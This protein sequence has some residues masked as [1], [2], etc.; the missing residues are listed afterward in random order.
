MVKGEERLYSE[1]RKWLKRKDLI[2]K[3]DKLKVEIKKE[4][5]KT[6]FSNKMVLIQSRTQ[7]KEIALR[8]GG[9]IFQV[10]REL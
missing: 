8:R 7:M 1:L 3:R 4:T 2:L 9:G 5:Y 6:R 10:R